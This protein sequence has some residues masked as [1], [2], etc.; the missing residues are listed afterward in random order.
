MA[1]R[2]DAL[3]EPTCEAL[4]M[5]LKG[6]VDALANAVNEV[7]WAVTA[8]ALKGKDEALTNEGKKAMVHLRRAQDY[9]CGPSPSRSR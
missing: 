5:E 1:P 2:C 8:L 7:A 6:Q 3:G 9:L 4:Q